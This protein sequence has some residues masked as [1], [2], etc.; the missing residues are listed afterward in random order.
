MSELKNGFNHDISNQ[1]YHDDRKYISSSGL[2]MILKDPRQFY[3]TYVLNEKNESTNQSAMDLGSYIHALI[4]EPHLVEEEFA[5]FEGAM[6]RGSQ[7]EEFSANVKEGQTI[8]TKSQ[9]VQAQ[10]LVRNFYETEL[11]LGDDLVKVSS[12]FE[13]GRAEETLCGE[14]DGL[15]VKVR[16]DYRKEGDGYASI[17]DIKTTSKRIASK[18]DA[19]EVCSMFGYHISAALYCDLVE[20]ETGKKHDFYFCFL[21]KKDGQTT[22]FKASEQMLEK[23]RQDYKR[24]IELIKKGRETGVWYEAKVETIDAI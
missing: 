7:W 19:E 17:N 15:P 18:R 24:A 5:V 3:K 4:L 11:E 14:L 9:D 1:D 10:E 6:R 22:L 2:K 12:F 8:I 20:K 16:F 21:S 23:G 13:E